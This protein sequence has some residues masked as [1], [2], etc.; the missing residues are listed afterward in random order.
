MTTSLSASATRCRIPLLLQATVVICQVAAL[1]GCMTAA[2]HAAQLPSASERQMTLGVAQKEIKK[3]MS[4]GDVAAVLGAPNIVSQ[5]ADGRETWI[6]DKIATEVAYSQSSV[7]GG[8]GGLL[9]GVGAGVGGGA[10]GGI[11]A[12]QSAGA[13]SQTQRTLTVV[14]KFRNGLVDDMS[15]HSSSF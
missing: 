14:I 15:Y 11:G 4:Q 2:Q 3:G 12:S 10:L 1:S 6:Y 9:I 13:A 5:D 8:I 7:S